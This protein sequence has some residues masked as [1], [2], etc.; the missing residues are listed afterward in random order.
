MN[1]LA[2]TTRASW[3]GVSG[4]CVLYHYFL[5]KLYISKFPGPGLNNPD[6]H[7]SA[8]LGKLTDSQA[9]SVFLLKYITYHCR[10]LK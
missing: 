5:W 1:L 10:G 4:L 3:H 2:L 9:A 7:Q 6:S 8:L